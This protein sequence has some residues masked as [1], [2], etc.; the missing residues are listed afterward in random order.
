MSLKVIRIRYTYIN[1]I[2][3]Y[4]DI[5]THNCVYIYNIHIYIYLYIYIYIYII[6]IHTY[7]YNYITIHK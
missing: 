5:H 2:H 1:Y 7:I 4:H 3:K 6:Y